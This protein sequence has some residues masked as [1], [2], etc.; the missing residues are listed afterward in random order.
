ML[1]YH[2]HTAAESILEQADHNKDH[3]GLTYWENTPDGKILKSDVSVAKNYFY[4][5]EKSFLE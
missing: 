1:R 4:E 2:R 5:K 3:N